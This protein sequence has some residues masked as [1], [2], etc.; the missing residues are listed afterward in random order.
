MLGFL[1][2]GTAS[3]A[4]ALE[5]YATYDGGG[6]YHDVVRAIAVDPAGNPIAAGDSH[7][8]VLGADMVVRK[9][10]RATGA[11]QWTIRQSAFD[12]SSIEVCGTGWDSWGRLFAGGTLL[13]CGSG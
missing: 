12:T 8:G 11:A 13:G 5:W 4:P 6:A 3:G 2:P 10:D 1:A 9:Y 7:D